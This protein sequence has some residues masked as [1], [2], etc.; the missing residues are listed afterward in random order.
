[1]SSPALQATHSSSNS[2]PLILIVPESADAGSDHWQ[3]RWERR[4]DNCRRLDLGMWDEPH[5]NTWINKLNLAIYRADRPVLLV[6]HGLGCLTVAWWA[7]YERPTAGGAVVGALLVAPPDPDRAPVDDPRLAKFA[8]C[9][10]RPLPF[11]AFVVAS[12]DD[13]G[14][15]VRGAAQLARE[16]DCR[17]ADAGPAGHLDANSNVGDWA[18]GRRLVGQLLN[19]YRPGSYAGPMMY[20]VPAGPTGRIDR[21][22]DS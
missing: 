13:P 15:S 21:S 2:D 18:L 7:E 8:S 4:R 3:T 20:P 17:L 22:L 10:R 1:M 9:P 11:P 16:W 5:R 6:A 14:C 12:A 19:E